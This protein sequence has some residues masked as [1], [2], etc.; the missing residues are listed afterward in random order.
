MYRASEDEEKPDPTCTICGRSD[1]GRCFLCSENVYYGLSKVSCKNKGCDADF[2]PDEL[3][4][5]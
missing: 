4:P 2:H 3:E 1:A 5:V